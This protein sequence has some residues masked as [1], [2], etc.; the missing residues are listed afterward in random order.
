[1]Q[2]F[3]EKSSDFV[4]LTLANWTEYSK[5]KYNLIVQKNRE[6]FAVIIFDFPDIHHNLKLVL[7]YSICWIVG[8]V[9][10][11]NPH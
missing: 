3:Q 6:L 4:V 1:L 10:T 9:F 5:D 8:H 11:E 7:G 2:E